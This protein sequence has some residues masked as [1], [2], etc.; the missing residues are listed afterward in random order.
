MPCPAS[1]KSQYDIGSFLEKL[2]HTRLQNKRL[3]QTPPTDGGMFPKRCKSTPAVRAGIAADSKPKDCEESSLNIGGMCPKDTCVAESR[4]TV[5]QP[6]G[7][8]R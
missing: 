4:A 1:S 3:E 7:H 2:Q 6:W 5:H 8:D